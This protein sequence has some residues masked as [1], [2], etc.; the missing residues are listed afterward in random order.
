LTQQLAGAGERL[1]GQ[2]PLGGNL[3]NLRLQLGIIDLEEWGAAG[4]ERSLAYQDL[5]QPAFDIGTEL[6]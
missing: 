1:S 4:H 6:D 2:I 5:N 3:R